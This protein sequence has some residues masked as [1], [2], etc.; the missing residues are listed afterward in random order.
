MITTQSSRTCSLK[1]L[2]IRAAVHR[3]F[4]CMDCVLAFGSQPLHQFR[5]QR[6][7]DQKLHRLSSIVSSSER[8]AA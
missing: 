4:I 6:H 7:I 5:R 8:Q 3:E 1:D 2:C